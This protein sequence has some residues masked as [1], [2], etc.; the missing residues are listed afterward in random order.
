MPERIEILL[1][2]LLQVPPPDP[3]KA[4][5]LMDTEALRQVEDDEGFAHLEL[6]IYQIKSLRVIDT[7]RE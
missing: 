5:V 1:P 6:D 4:L 7:I 3:L 2:S